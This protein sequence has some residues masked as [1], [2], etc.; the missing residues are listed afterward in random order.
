[1]KK[2][3]KWGLVIT[4][5]CIME[6]SWANSNDEQP[7]YRFYAVHDDS[8]NDSQFITISSDTLEVNTLGE[9]HLAY[10]IE[11]L[12]AHPNTQVLYAG[13]G[14]QTDQKGVLYT[15]DAQTGVLTEIGYTG[16]REI[17]A[18]SFHP[19]GTLWGWAKGKGL[20]E[21]N[22]QTGAG[23]LVAPFK[24][25][26]E[27]MTWDNEGTY[28]YAA[29]D[30]YLWV[31]DGQQVKKACDLPGHTEAL[32]ML[33]DG[34]LLIGVH[35]QK[36][37][38]SF[39]T[40]NL[41]TCEIVKGI[42]IPTDFDDVEGI[43]W[44]KITPEPGISL[45]QAPQTALT[46]KEGST[47]Y[48][49][50]N[51]SLLKEDGIPY[52]LAFSQTITPDV[53]GIAIVYDGWW[54]PGAM[55]ITLD[56]RVTGLKSGTYT[57][58]STVTIVET[59]ESA[60]QTLLVKVVTPEE[61]NK[62]V[63]MPPTSYP[64][65]IKIGVPTQVIFAGSCRTRGKLPP[66]LTLEEVTEDGIL[67]ATLGELRNDGT[68]GDMIAGDRTY[69]GT[70]TVTSTVEGKKIYRTAALHNGQRV[71][72]DIGSLLI[73]RFPI[74]DS[75]PLNLNNWTSDPITGISI[76]SDKIII[77]FNEGTSPDRIEEIV[78]V[79]GAIIV[80]MIPSIEKLLIHFSG[81]GTV[82]FVRKLV[83]V[84][85]GTYPEVEYV[86]AVF[87]TE[88]FSSKSYVP[89][90]PKF[91]LQDGMKTVRADET[92][93]I[94]RGNERGQIAI[95]DTGVDSSHLDLTNVKSGIN[96]LDDGID[97]MD[98]ANK[99]GILGHGTLVAGIAA[100]T[101]NN[102]EGIAGVAGGSPIVVIKAVGN[103]HGVDSLA[104]ALGIMK[105]TDEFKSPIINVSAGIDLEDGEKLHGGT[106][107]MALEHVVKHATE[108]DLLVVA[109]AGNDG[110]S[111]EFIPCA[112]GEV[113]CVGGSAIQEKGWFTKQIEKREPN[114]NYGSWV[115]IAAPYRAYST[116][117]HNDYRYGE[118][119]SYSTPFVSGAASVLLSMHPYM[120]PAE[121]KE[122]LIK[123]GKPL[124]GS[125]IGN[126]LD[127]FEAVFNGSFETGDLSEWSKEGKCLNVTEQGPIRPIHGK[128]MA[129]C[130]IGPKYGRKAILTKTFTVQ[131]GVT[132]LPIEF[133]FEFITDAYPE[134][135]NNRIYDTFVR[136]TFSPPN[137]QSYRIIVAGVADHGW[138]LKPTT[139]IDLGGNQTVGWIGSW[140]LMRFDLPVTEGI[141]TFKVE[142]LND[143]HNYFNAAVLI[144]KFQ[145]KHDDA[146]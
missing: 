140:G 60:S 128:R 103:V 111:K 133:H 14:D 8:L 108:L 102:E 101:L 92:W 79:E 88:L 130:Q 53:D 114:S 67:I 89:K 32:E 142:L 24:V 50:F 93:L 145:L 37:L 26:V 85:V 63:L 77:S 41:K 56:E 138:S 48:L 76:L 144:D 30:T 120:T 113:L 69:S 39:K 110:E 40:F 91:S 20:I 1:M 141:G 115:D 127:V 62:L 96:L 18:L 64:G 57:L 98:K 54:K 86:E 125:Q 80:G 4:L 44:L 124:P 94:A 105:A 118:G 107:N 82:E 116:A 31:Y 66:V 126:R 134:L 27:G 29:Q 35:G 87:K 75:V 112:F 146:P 104:L 9:I 109:A 15:V 21:I 71:V 2:I 47:D 11:A 45:A 3:A 17:E 52:Q 97:Y 122:R 61:L 49:S 28:L 121:I 123:T 100:A 99:D 135:L 12:D 13:S 78:T 10:D 119:T 74:I 42:D 90:D 137:G 25:Q 139:D 136:F 19:N 43:T 81:D 23:K 95:V 106:G 132:Q 7:I 65:G 22:P 70:F 46:I 16:F 6:N 129:L 36:T 143:G 34:T 33:P 5:F 51:I 83:A 84:F 73:T 72:S 131:P 117:P 58:T 59:G 68:N 55:S 38:L